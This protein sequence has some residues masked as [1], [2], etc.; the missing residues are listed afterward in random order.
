MEQPIIIHF[1]WTADELLRAQDYHFRHTCRPIFRFALHFIFGLMILGGCGLIHHGGPLIPVGVGLIGTGVYWFTLRRFDRRRIVRVR[2][3]KR[4][5]RDVEF[6]WQIAPDK[7]RTH[8]TLG[9]GEFTWQAFAK[10]VRTPCG[11]LLYPTDQIFHWLPRSGFAS[12]TDFER[13]V[14]LAKK[15]IERHYDVA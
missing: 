5:D 4:P 12:D 8:S 10:M 11:I 6:E 9:Q 1:R 14:E 3:S 15:N 2:L 13:C 7:I